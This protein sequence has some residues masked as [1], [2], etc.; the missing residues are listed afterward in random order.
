MPPSLVAPTAE[1]VP[2]LAVTAMVVHLV[3][4]RT[5]VVVDLS[6]GVPTVRHWGARIPDSD[7]DDLATAIERRIARLTPGP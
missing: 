2:C 3:G 4:D 5:S 6:T 7:V 1:R